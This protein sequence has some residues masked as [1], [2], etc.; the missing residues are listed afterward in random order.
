MSV[1]IIPPNLDPNGQTDSV[2]TINATIS[3]VSA[4]GGGTVGLPR[5]IYLA[6]ADT[7]RLKSNVRLQ[8]EDQNLTTIK[9]GPG[10]NSNLVV[11]PNSLASPLI[12]ATIEDICFDGNAAAQ[13]AA[14]YTIGLQ[15]IS[16][17][18]MVGVR[19]INPWS[20]SL[21]IN[22]DDQGGGTPG[23]PNKPYGTYFNSDVTIERCQFS[24]L[25]VP[26]ARGGGDHVVLGRIRGLRAI[27]N[28]FVG[29]SQN[30]LA[31]QFCT[32]FKLLANTVSDFWRGIYLES[33]ISGTIAQNTVTR[34]GSPDPQI[35]LA[36][37]HG[38]WLTSADDTYG[39]NA[40]YAGCQDVLVA[41]NVVASLS[42]QNGAGVAGV[43][44]TDY[45]P[46]IRMAW[47][48]VVTD[49]LISWLMPSSGTAMSCG[50][51]MDARG[52]GNVLNGNRMSGV[53]SAKILSAHATQ[54][55][56]GTNFEGS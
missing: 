5:G 29:G 54:I 11:G 27:G 34:L 3:S 18:R 48:N 53:R 15:H 10:R 42:P 22:E 32:D 19:C 39:V 41:Q 4:A 23:V 6:A 24:Q 16:N 40:G 33:C 37:A 38:I 9:L 45:G 25:G 14:F 2:A 56:M 49:N 47:N 36:T 17:F 55:M 26:A 12:G 28:K 1:A 44:V 7:L 30:G 51:W 20:T 43:R 21:W 46:G 13:Q 31:V 52:H 8:G 50:A 35:G